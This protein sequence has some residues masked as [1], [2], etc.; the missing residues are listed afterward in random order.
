MRNLIVLF[1]LSLGLAYGQGPRITPEQRQEILDYKLSMA[2]ANQIFTALDAMTKYVVSLP[3][4]ASVMAKQAKMTPAER[5]ASVEND[6]KAMA[7]LKQN[8]LTAKEYLIGVPALRWAIWLAE[9][10]NGNPEVIASPGNLA[11]AKANLTQLK[12]RLDVADGVSGA[13]N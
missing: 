8:G 12:P 2:R 11:F 10:R 9:G 1:A 4:L 6:T 5:L 13:H 7:I 3:D